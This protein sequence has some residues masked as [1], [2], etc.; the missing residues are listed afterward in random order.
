MK[1]QIVN[2]VWT[3]H[4]L[5]PRQFLKVNGK[6]FKAADG[7]TDTNTYN[8]YLRKDRFTIETIRHELFHCY[9]DST[10]TESAFLSKDQI[11]E[12]AASLMGK[13][14]KELTDK[15]DEVFNFFINKL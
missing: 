14:C 2:T 6:S 11:E 7:V 3:I 10:H 13:Y 4:L 8:V 9:F 5:G 1:I 15:S 12:T